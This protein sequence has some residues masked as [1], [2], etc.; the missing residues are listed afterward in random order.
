M[1]LYK[2]S[3]MCAHH[4]QHTSKARNVPLGLTARLQPPN[5]VIAPIVTSGKGLS[6]G[7]QFSIL[8]GTYT[9]VTPIFEH[10]A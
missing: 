6:I 3:L 8:L 5:G 1:Y 9:H 2:Q 7:C 10:Y 4:W